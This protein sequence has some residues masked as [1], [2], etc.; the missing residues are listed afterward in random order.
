MTVTGGQD[1]PWLL[2]LI[3]AHSSGGS[4][5]RATGCDSPSGA[6]TSVSATTNTGAIVSPSI[7]ET[8]DVLIYIGAGYVGLAPPL[9]VHLG[10]GTPLTSFIGIHGVN[11][12]FQQLLTTFG[13]AVAPGDV[14]VTATGPSAYTLAAGIV[15]VYPLAPP[16]GNAVDGGYAGRGVINSAF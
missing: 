11:G 13:T 15:A 9:N 4:A 12:S 8:G 2:E 3:V 7:P 10:A 1:A 16:L 6:A 5:L 14:S